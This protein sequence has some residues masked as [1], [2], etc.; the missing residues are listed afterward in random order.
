MADNA[1]AA[2]VQLSEPAEPAEPAPQP[3]E[4]DCAAED[5]HGEEAD[6]APGEAA[7]SDCAAEDFLGE[8]PDAPPAR[9][10]RG[11]ARLI[12]G[13]GVVVM[14]A[15][16]GLGGWLGFRAY[17]WHQTQHQRALFVAVAR[18]GAM[19]LTTIDYNEADADVQRILSSAT[20]SFYDDFSKRSQPFIDVVKQ[21]RSKSEG[22][23][24]EAGVES[25]QG[26]TA[27]VLVAVT[28]NTSNAG[29]PE[30]APRLWRMRI[31]VQRVGDGAKI[32]SVE[33]VP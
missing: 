25:E 23:V 4:S 19:N 6:A 31:A 24:T 16:A 27:Q 12:I 3:A 18:Q 28:V 17:Q 14:L 8:E 26:S 13:V 21:A 2:A 15:L 7:E 11:R 9:P 10:P 20:G 1:D 29:A 30:Q 32:S 5:S 22:T 33:F